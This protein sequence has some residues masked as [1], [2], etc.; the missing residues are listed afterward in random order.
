[1]MIAHSTYEF[2]REKKEGIFSVSQSLVYPKTQN[3]VRGTMMS[4]KRRERTR[5]RTERELK[6]PIRAIETSDYVGIHLSLL[7]PRRQSSHTAILLKK[8][9]SVAVTRAS[10]KCTVCVRLFLRTQKKAKK[11]KIAN[12][13]HTRRD[14]SFAKPAPLALLA[15]RT[16]LK[17][18]V[19]DC[20][21]IVLFFS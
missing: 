3:P 2:L 6:P 16:P 15:I 12:E 5:S 7:R 21:F 13:K 8:I 19:A 11:R 4:R 20:M 14:E 1:M 17:L 18:D 9:E 10:A